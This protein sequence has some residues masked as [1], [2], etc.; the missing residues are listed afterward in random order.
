[1]GFNDCRERQMQ[2]REFTKLALVGA[3]GAV[4]A[5]AVVKATDIK[6]P[7]RLA[8]DRCCGVVLDVQ[9]SFLDNWIR[10]VVTRSSETQRALSACSVITEFR[11]S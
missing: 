7:K 10:V 2:R 1:M 6:M 3:A 9:G 11:L 8:L 4:A 5:T